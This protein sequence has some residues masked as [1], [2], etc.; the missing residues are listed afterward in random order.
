M[1]GYGYGQVYRPN[2]RALPT[3]ILSPP[4]FARA[5]GG[6]GPPSPSPFS[7]SYSGACVSP[8]PP[9]PFSPGAIPVPLQTY[10]IAVGSPRRGYAPVFPSSPGPR[11]VLDMNAAPQLD[12]SQIDTSQVDAE[13]DQGVDADQADQG[14]D[15]DQVNE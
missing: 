8:L 13:A 10:T 4:P 12:T 14:V 9:P 15:A 7:P 6:Y 3:V 1:Y 2:A 11:A 5:R